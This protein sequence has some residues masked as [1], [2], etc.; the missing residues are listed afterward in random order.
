[1]LGVLR[2]SFLSSASAH[3][4][5]LAPRSHDFDPSNN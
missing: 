3:F 4:L 1:V 5:T 2:S